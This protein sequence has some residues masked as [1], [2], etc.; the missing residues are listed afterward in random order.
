[1]E[2]GWTLKETV[3]VEVDRDVI[4]GSAHGMMF[5]A[6]TPLNATIPI[7][8]PGTPTFLALFLLGCHNLVVICT[9]PI[10]T[11]VVI[12]VKG[13]KSGTVLPSTITV[14]L[15]R[16]RIGVGESVGVSVGVSVVPPSGS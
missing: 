6:A 10:G 16:L 5:A 2:V 13:P 14:V 12:I 4:E 7:N 1:M 9:P 11:V 8:K 15:V 3:R